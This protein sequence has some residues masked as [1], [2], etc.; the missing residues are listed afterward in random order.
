MLSVTD[1]K[2][3]HKVLLALDLTT[4]IFSYDTPLE[5]FTNSFC[6]GVN[7]LVEDRGK[8]ARCIGSFSTMAERRVNFKVW[9]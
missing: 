8:R 4:H 3:I 7:K 2:G 1:H 9:N 5:T 6:M